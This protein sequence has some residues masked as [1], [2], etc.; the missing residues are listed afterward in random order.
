MLKFTLPLIFLI[1][2]LGFIFVI[3]NTIQDLPQPSPHPS[4]IPS[5]IPPA[6]TQKISLDEIIQNEL[7]NINGS[8]GIVVKNLKT[9]EIYYLNEHKTFVSAS[10][11][12]LWVM[13]TAYKQINDGILSEDDI[14]DSLNKMITISDNETSLLLS[15]KVG[16][17]N[18]DSFL[19][20]NGLEESK[21][22]LETPIVTA[23]DIALF[24]EK[25]YKGKLANP[26]NTKKMLDLLKAQEINYG[27]PKYLPDNIVIAHKTGK[28]DEFSHDAGIIYTP[29]GDYIIAI[30]TE[31]DDNKNG[32]TTSAEEQIAKI[33]L[34]VY[35]YFTK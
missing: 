12:K 29:K 27:I 31:S 10:L 14:I 4:V 17:L 3:K 30:L 19:H 35:N 5:T 16:L 25:L 21:I 24:F 9:S 23:S 20:S 34:A 11:Y 32:D 33:S 26:Q 28:L 15:E 22:L 2:L 7:T 13:A 18:V 6:K 8:Y 1:S